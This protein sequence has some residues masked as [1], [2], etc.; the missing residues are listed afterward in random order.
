MRGEMRQFVETEER[1]L[2]PLPVVHRAVE[3]QVRELD[4]TAPRPAPFTRSEVRPPAEPWIK[5]LAFIPQS[6][7]VGD[8]RGRAPEEHCGE[9]GDPADM[10]QRLKDEADR[11]AAPGRTAIDADIGG[12]LQKRGL[13]SRL[14]GNCQHQ[15][16]P[17]VGIRWSRMHAVNQVS[18][19]WACGHFL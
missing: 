12:S 15:V 7:R 8:L 9:V 5:V 4:L 3:L 16:N 10:A 6:T 18:G 17:V 11:F 19:S 1:D 2:G 14:S 13:R